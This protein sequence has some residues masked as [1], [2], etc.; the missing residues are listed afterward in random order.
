MSIF[1]LWGL[2]YERISGGD[3]QLQARFAQAQAE[4]RANGWTPVIYMETDSDMLQSAAED[5]LDEFDSIDAFA[6]AVR[7]QAGEISVSDYRCDEWQR[8][9]ADRA[10]GMFDDMEDGETED[11]FALE[12]AKRIFLVKVPVSEPWRVFERVPFGGFGSCPENGVHMAFAKHWHEKYGAV[13]AIVSDCSVQ[14]LLPEK[15]AADEAL[16][17]QLIQ[18]CPS[19]T[20]YIHP[21][22]FAAQF[23]PVKVWFFFWD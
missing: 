16:N 8:I 19:L 7:A 12:G 2:P 17:E 1:D 14:Y 3:Q 20:E 10:A 6:A 4:G 9:Q 5:V 21:D 23:A 18:Y 11:G 22:S 15:A 13:P